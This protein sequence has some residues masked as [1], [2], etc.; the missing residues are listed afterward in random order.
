MT[1][2]SLVDLNQSWRGPAGRVLALVARR[3]LNRRSLRVQPRRASPRCL[4]ADIQSVPAHEMRRSAGDRPAGAMARLTLARRPQR[5]M[6]YGTHARIRLPRLRRTSR[7][8]AGARRTQPERAH[9]SGVAESV[10]LERIVRPRKRL[11]DQR[12]EHLESLSRRFGCIAAPPCRS[13]CGPGRRPPSRAHLPSSSHSVLRPAG[14][15]RRTIH[16]TPALA[17]RPARP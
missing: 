10:I 16:R 9:A 2:H 14:R 17:I 4:L 11:V 1:V 7:L 5:G 3:R 15:N 12:P 6:S 13:T 8:T